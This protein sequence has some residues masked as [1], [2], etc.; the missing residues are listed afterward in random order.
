MRRK[1]HH[2]AIF[3]VPNTITFAR[4]V[5][6]VCES[7]RYAK[8]G[9]IQHFFRGLGIFLL[10]VLDGPAARKLNQETEFGKQF[11][12]IV[13][14]ISVATL[15]TSAVMHGEADWP[16]VAIVG[17][18]NA[19]NMAATAVAKARNVP[20][21]VTKIGKYSQFGMNTGFG[22]HVAGKHLARH[23][24][25]PLVRGAGQVL[26]A[27]GGT[28]AALVALSMGVQA[29]EVYWDQALN[30][31]PPEQDHTN[32]TDTLITATV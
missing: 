21:E 5:G 12:P 18:L 32:T 11:D 14:K 25:S 15:A 26:R 27:F 13:D 3:N 10:D 28:G 29:T 22:L 20:I 30:G 1:E 6:V 7:A 17:T 4:L 19:S 9:G 8:T 23:S 31:L 16:V 24:E 2:E